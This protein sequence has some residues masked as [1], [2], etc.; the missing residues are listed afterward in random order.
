MLCEQCRK[1]EED[2]MLIYLARCAVTT[3]AV[4]QGVAAVPIDCN[5]THAT[6]PLWPGHA[7]FHVVWQAVSSLLLGLAEA[8]LIWWKGPQV[9]ARFYL[10]ALLAALPQIG[11]LIALLARPSYGGTLHD[12]NGI[13]PASLPIAGRRIQVDMNAVLV[14]AALCILLAAVLTCALHA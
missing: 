9:S 11:F 2:S 7:R 13:R 3:I 12:P 1:S 10:A 5:R 6:N 8:G 14:T 4:A